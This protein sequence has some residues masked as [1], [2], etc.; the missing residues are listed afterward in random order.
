MAM[1]ARLIVN[2]DDFGRSRSL[3]EGVIAAFERGILTSTS[4]VAGGQDFEN[5]VAQAKLHSGLGVGVH[6]AID[7]YRPLCSPGRIASLVG[8]DG[9]FR[10]RAR[11]L[12]NIFLGRV[13]SEELR[14]EW[15]A[16]VARVVDA[17]LRP[18]HLDGH[19]HCHATPPMAE[20]V[21][22]VAAR[23]G[24]PAVRRPAEPLLHIGEVSAFSPARYL[25]K[26]LVRAAGTRAAT[27]WRGRLRYPDE[28]AGFIEAGQLRPSRL[29]SLATS[30]HSGVTELM[31]HPGVSDDDSP[32]GV[33]YD[34]RGD[35]AALTKW[36]KEEFE[37]RFDVRLV[38]YRT[39]WNGVR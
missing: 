24:I 4:I 31:A 39:A 22:D 28:F 20:L 21:A 19:G 7:E 35:L 34:W 10:S 11:M 27:H 13:V 23:F 16:Q 3:T 29:E 12:R 18:S 17:G 36:S 26:I 38:S 37:A 14:R 30:L 15:E 25:E 6:L 1:T 33:A 32:Y 5:A 2:G 9:A 8:P